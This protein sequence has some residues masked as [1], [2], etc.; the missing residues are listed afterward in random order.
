MIDVD[1][2]KPRS[3]REKVDHRARIARREDDEAGED[4]VLLTCQIQV[5]GVTDCG[6]GCDVD[7]TSCQK[8][9][10]HGGAGGVEEAVEGRHVRLLLPKRDAV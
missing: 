6:W 7:L 9:L 5:R 2:L 4:V 10:R 3:T 1:N 8:Q